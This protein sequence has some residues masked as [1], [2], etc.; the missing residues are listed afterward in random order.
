VLPT[1]E[2]LA[3]RRIGRRREGTA[4]FLVERSPLSLVT[5]GEQW[6]L[7]LSAHVLNYTDGSLRLRRMSEGTY[8]GGIRSAPSSRMTSPL[9]MRFSTIWQAS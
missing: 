5:G 6:G 3:N 8:R 1:P 4:L 9:S 7:G 2:Q